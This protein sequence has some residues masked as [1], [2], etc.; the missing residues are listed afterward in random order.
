MSIGTHDL[1]TIQG[2]FV[3]DAKAPA[4]I[5]FVALSQTKEHTAAELLE[6]YKDSHLKPYLQIIKG[7]KHPVITDSNGVIMSIPPI[8]NGNHSKITLKTRNIFI[9]ITATDKKKANVALDTIVCNFSSH[10]DVPFQIEPVDVELVDGTTLVTPA[11]PYRFV[12]TAIIGASFWVLALFM[13]CLCLNHII[14]HFLQ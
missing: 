12:L 11:L 5:S 2:P 7:P 6:L 1:D 10:C 13:I 4:D 8:I 3:Y 9:E 14:L